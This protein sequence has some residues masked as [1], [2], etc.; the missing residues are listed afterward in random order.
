MTRTT[1]TVSLVG[2]AAAGL[3]AVAIASPAWAQATTYPQGTNCSVIQN[4]A[5]RTDCMNQMNESRQ[6][7]IPGTAVQPQ[8]PGT[9]VQPTPGGAPSANPNAPGAPSGNAPSGT[10]GTD[11]NGDAGNGMTN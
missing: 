4:S 9:A 1:L 10:T 8:V 3:I 6:N 2:S 11:T 7:Q 5:D